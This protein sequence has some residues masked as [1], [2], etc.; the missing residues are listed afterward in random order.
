MN[1]FL[2]H[3][4]LLLLP[5]LLSV[6]ACSTNQA[7]GRSSFTAFMD[8]DEERAVGKQEHVKVLKQFGGVYD[9]PDLSRYVT[10]I[11]E[12]L[13]AHSEHAG[14]DY[15]FTVLNSPVVNA[16]ALPGGY[17]YV[18]R[19]LLALTSNEAE[20]AGVIGHEIGH[21]TA[22]HTA[23]RYSQ[24]RAAQLGVQILDIIGQA[25]GLPS[26]V[27]NVAGVGAS[28]LLT[29]YSRDQETESD[30]LGVRYMTRAGYDPQA[31]ISFFT[32]LRMASQLEQTLAGKDPNSVDQFNIM[33]THPRTADRI[34][35][36]V[37]LASKNG[38]KNPRIGAKEL[39]SHINGIAY[40]DDG[41]QGTIRLDRI[42]EH[43][44]LDVRFE[45]PKGY[46][47][48]NLPDRVT[49]KGPDAALMTF[50]MASKRDA[51]KASSA[52]DYL[53]NDWA[54]RYDVR[55]VDTYRIN[56]M[57]VATGW[58]I[59][60][61]DQGNSR[62]ARFAVIDA[63]NN[64]MFRLQFSAPNR[65]TFDRHDTEFRDIMD[66]L[67]RLTRAER[68]ENA[69]PSI[70]VITVQGGDTAEKLARGMAVE[71]HAVEHF[72]AI[73]GITRDQELVIDSK[74]KIIAR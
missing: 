40:G 12:D 2:R 65:R 24:A 56:R 70:R 73:N 52:R 46:S 64:Q 67:R 22:R 33:S 35:Q 49:A 61:T 20:L 51:Q 29:S 1:Q 48:E 66:S 11:G 69:A 37:K 26:G 53:I 17:V 27:G 41:S 74:V 7:T 13:L 34:T 36:A 5:L 57:D 44:P 15:T 18:S 68:T 71:S 10:Q 43:G 59:I 21:V 16:F 62:Y 55:D 32:K 8:E 54:T 42:F 58:A 38:V 63:G 30:T 45:V 4:R 25:A 31:T 3:T 23:E 50:T 39:L 28:L 14:K 6:A 19:G 47:L 9:N 72:E 60:R